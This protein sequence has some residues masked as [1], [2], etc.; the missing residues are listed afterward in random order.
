MELCQ[1]QTLKLKI[2]P[3]L[4]QS[5]N[6]LQY[7]S[8]EL[9]DFIR[10]QAVENPILEVNENPVVGFSSRNYTKPSSGSFTGDPNY[11]PI[12]HYTDTRVTLEKHLIEQVMLLKNKTPLQITILK[13]LIGNLNQHGFLEIEPAIAARY[14]SVTDE[15]MENA[16]H[17]LQSLDP[18]GVGAR[19]FVD[20]LLI[21]LR[22]QPQKHPL[23]H[24]IVVNYLEDLAAKRYPRLA[25]IFN[26]TVYEIQET[27]DYIATLNP[28]PCSEFSYEL[29]QYVEPDVI[30]ENIKDKFVIIVNDAMMP[31]I[32]IKHFYKNNL[33]NQDTK[34]YLKDK[35]HD[36]MIL[37]N[38]IAQ[39][40]QTLYKV[41]Q[42][43]VEKQNEFLKYGM[44]SLKPMTLKDIAEQTGFH[45]STVS[46][47]TSNKYIKTSYGLFLLK[48][49]FTAGINRSNSFEADSSVAV[50]K[51]IKAFID[52]E[53]KQK[54]LS[55]QKIVQQLENCGILI[56][57]RTVAKYR[58]EIGIPGSSKR[59]RF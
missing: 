4:R 44:A 9:T 41:T 14:F 52:E 5:I 7:S 28:R 23:A 57:R 40:K 46:R 51:K 55:D 59:K 32:S 19:N 17:L 25:K 38:G 35:Y 56:S 10:Q 12:N 6:I 37:M 26:V 33:K 18:I 24:P 21:Q 36:A 53:N 45:E 22:A 27:A 54:P 20:C 50:K 2:T 13:F 47:A 48:S 1:T 39:R 31:D 30:V 8:Q 43:I 16:I 15:E 29:T 42:A 34:D 58:E 11:N 3:E 49:L